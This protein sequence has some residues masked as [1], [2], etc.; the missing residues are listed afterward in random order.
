MSLDLKE[1]KL[2][3]SVLVDLSVVVGAV[4]AIIKFRLYNLL[5]RRY[6]SELVC[7][8]H[9][10]PSGKVVFRADYSV[11][12]I[13]QRALQLNGLTIMLYGSTCKEN[14]LEPD[15]GQLLATKIYK[16]NDPDVRR[17]F[18][19][20]AGERSIFSFQCEL[21]ELKPVVF[22]RCE[23]TTLQ[24]FSASPFIE[25]YVRSDKSAT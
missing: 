24:R 15:Y 16:E 21:A 6:R 8:H 12:N 3:T 23:T 20:E 22:V 11:H 13:G 10:M 4:A 14:I 9:V 7:T 2:I 17:V 1:V 19:I 25:M 18:Q 5:G